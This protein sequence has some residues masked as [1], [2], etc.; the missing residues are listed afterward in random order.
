M[1]FCPWRTACSRQ[2]PVNSQ[3]LQ[4]A[5]KTYG[6]GTTSG[7]QLLSPP[8]RPGPCHCLHPGFNQVFPRQLPRFREIIDDPVRVLKEDANRRPHSRFTAQTLSELPEK[9][10]HAQNDALGHALWFRSQL[11]NTGVLPLTPEDAEIHTLFLT[12]SMPSNT[13][14]TGTA[15]RGKRAEKSIIPASARSSLA[16]K[17]CRNTTPRRVAPET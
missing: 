15:A 16:S 6:S 12:T 2:V 9:W 8:R 14:R 5:I 7:G 3:I 1:K 10:P 4:P 17:R 13:G 11:A